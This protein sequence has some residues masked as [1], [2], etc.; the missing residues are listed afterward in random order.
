M[1]DRFCHES[2]EFKELSEGRLELSLHLADLL[3]AER[4]IFN[5]AA[6]PRHWNHLP[7]DPV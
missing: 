5:G 2:Q 7:Y 3:E 1:R 6:T 4:L